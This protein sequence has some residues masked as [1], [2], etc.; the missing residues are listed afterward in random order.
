M[1]ALKKYNR[2]EAVGFWTE[3]KDLPKR[4]VIVSF[5][6]A[7]ILLTDKSETPLTHWSINSL[8]VIKKEGQK[9]TYSVGTEKDEIL[10]IED[11]EMIKAINIFS[12][13]L[14]RFKQNPFNS[15]KI[16][17]ILV[18]VFSIISISY[19]PHLIREVALKTTP[20]ERA[21]LMIFQILKTQ[22]D[23][24]GKICYPNENSGEFGDLIEKVNSDNP[25]LFISVYDSPSTEPHLLPGAILKLPSQFLKN[26]KGPNPLISTI[27]KAKELAKTKNLTKIFF[28]HQK[29][30][31]ILK[32]I[33]GYNSKFEFPNDIF[34]TISKTDD[35]T[36]PINSFGFID[37]QSWVKIQ[38]ICLN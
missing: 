17:W 10:E 8:L 12:K 25:I 14:E 24:L 36:A 37:D 9:V 32:Y 16:I 2:L 23:G 31:E 30:L 19:L 33:L 20:M 1:T 3:S 38:N 18:L 22:E 11:P 28:Q 21:R 7:S 4:E 35:K 27:I 29:P 15:R 13:K 6:K 26:T 5:G 34:F